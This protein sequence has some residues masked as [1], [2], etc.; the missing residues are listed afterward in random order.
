MRAVGGPTAPIPKDE[1]EAAGLEKALQKDPEAG[2]LTLH[3]SLDGP[4]VMGP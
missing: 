2:T 1:T 3:S 4:S